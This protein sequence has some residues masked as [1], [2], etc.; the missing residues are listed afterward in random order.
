MTEGSLISRSMKEPPKLEG[1]EQLTKYLS[2]ETLQEINAL[3]EVAK[4][5]VPKIDVDAV[6]SNLEQKFDSVLEQY[7][8]LL[9]ENFEDVKKNNRE[10]EFLSIFL[11]TDADGL[12]KVD[13]HSFEFMEKYFPEEVEAVIEEIELGNWD[14]EYRDDT[15]VLKTGPEALFTK[16]KDWISKEYNKVDD[17]LQ[18]ELAIS[19]S[20]TEEQKK[21][22]ILYQDVMAIARYN[23]E[24]ETEIGQLKFLLGGEDHEAAE[25]KKR[26]EEAAEEEDSAQIDKVLHEIMQT[27]SPPPIGGPE[28]VQNEASKAAVTKQIRNLMAGYDADYEGPVERLSIS[29]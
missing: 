2:E 5:A 11:D 3:F 18:N 7:K 20:I 14:T 15:R 24:L 12:P 10:L 23:K 17:D 1:Q 21:F 27:R 6:V 16:N 29:R 22:Q 13:M 19:A 28:H 25:K 9:I 26:A 4:T 8:D